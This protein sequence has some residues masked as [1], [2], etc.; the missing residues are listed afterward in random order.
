MSRATET[1]RHQND[2]STSPTWKDWLHRGGRLVVAA[3]KE[4]FDDNGP[5]WAA[6]LAYYTLLSVFPLLLVVAALAATVIDGQRVVDEAA[7][8]L[9]D[10]V[11]QNHERFAAIINGAMANR[12]QV[13][14]LSF[15]AL[16][17]TG[18]RVFATLIQALNIVYDIKKTYPVWQRLLIEVGFLLTLGVVIIAA[19]ASGLLVELLWRIVQIVPTHP[20]LTFTIIRG[21]V[22]VVLVGLA[23]FLIYRFVPRAQQHRTPAALGAGTATLLFLIA[24][25]L[26][27]FYLHR[28]GQYNLI[29]GS[30]TIVVTLLVWIWIVALI[31]LFGGEIAARSETMLGAEASDPE[32]TC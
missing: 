27:L 8:L 17:W 1:R 23:F 11:P 32:S 31:T 16:L 14:V 15:L 20:G 19:L 13:G 26:F 30:L 12:G 4:L 5:Q 22:R 9:G 2:S 3:G 6:A 10:L 29:Y 28:F 7:T 18:S 24:R 21:A 25:P